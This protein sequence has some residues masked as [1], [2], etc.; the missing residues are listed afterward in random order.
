MKMKN[1]TENKPTHIIREEEAIKLHEKNCPDVIF[2]NPVAA[3]IVRGVVA[4]LKPLPDKLDQH[5]T[6]R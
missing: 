4:E 3:T 6:Q 5:Q 2:C 1:K